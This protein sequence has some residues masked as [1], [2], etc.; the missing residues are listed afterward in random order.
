VLVDIPQ[1]SRTTRGEAVYLFTAIAGIEADR[2]RIRAADQHPPDSTGIRPP[3][4]RG[5]AILAIGFEH[6]HYH[7]I[8]PT[9]ATEWSRR[10]GL[11]T[12]IVNAPMGGT[13][14]GALAAAVSRAG[15][16]GMIGMGSAGSAQALAQQLNHVADLDYPFGIGLV[17]V[18][19]A[20]DP[21]L[22]P[23]AIA[24][25]PAVLSVSFADTWDWVASVRDAG[26]LAAAQVADL[27]GAQRA[28]E[29]GVDIIVAR[30]AEGG[31]HGA[32]S[33]GTLPLLTAVLDEVPLPVLAAGG[34]SS[35]RGLAAVLAAG[36]AGAWLGTAFAACTDSLASADTRTALLAAQD[37]DTTLTREFDIAAGY[38][39]PAHLPERV[40]RN[41][42]TSINAGQGVV[43][44]TGVQTAGDIVQ[45]LC[46]EAA[47][48]L[49]R[50][51]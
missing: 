34:I 18:S 27:R 23:T 2:D 19:M 15:G 28:A 45:Q 33:V 36:A 13:A 17:D 9:L 30:G 32:P 25:R 39:W 8:V 40:L 47:E 24:A 6:G 12:P 29:A 5:D 43:S 44:L 42:V 1:H 41:E 26:I 4:Q 11:A 50:W 46:A 21:H 22:L 20:R 51:R 14:G 35:G 48:L 7:T 31:G 10:L 3:L 38:A 16:L 49:R 37:T